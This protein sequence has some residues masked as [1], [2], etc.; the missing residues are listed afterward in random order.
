MHFPA[1]HIKDNCS[2]PSIKNT[3]EL[4]SQKKYPNEYLLFFL[5]SLPQGQKLSQT[6]IT[7]LIISLIHCEATSFTV[8]TTHKGSHAAASH[9]NVLKWPEHQLNI[10]SPFF[11]LND[12]LNITKIKIACS[13][14]HGKTNRHIIWNSRIMHLSA[15][16][17]CLQYCYFFLTGC[18]EFHCF[19]AL[20]SQGR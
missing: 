1:S 16:D 7:P 18:V 17:D 11:W 13:F 2:L 12:Q 15:D 9:V 6:Y 14:L 20:S 3:N 8:D 5:L 19:K 10:L 4:N